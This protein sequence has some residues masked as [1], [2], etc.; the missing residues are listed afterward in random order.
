MPLEAKQEEAPPEKE[1]SVS[2]NEQSLKK[3]K[4]QIRNNMIMAG[5]MP[6]LNSVIQSIDKVKAMQASQQ[7]DYERTALL[8]HLS[9][10][11]NSSSRPGGFLSK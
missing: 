4:Q 2:P 6:L 9:M 5:Q 3:K 11:H 7:R 10:T 1:E 8:S